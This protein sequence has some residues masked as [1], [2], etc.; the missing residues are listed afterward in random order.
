VDLFNAEFL[1]M[2]GVTAASVTGGL[3]FFGLLASLA[4]I[5]L[6][7]GGVTLAVFFPS[8]PLIW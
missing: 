5:G 3:S 6:I 4:V 7:G 8:S 2:A 1:S